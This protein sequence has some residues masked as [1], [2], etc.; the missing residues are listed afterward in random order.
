MLCVIIKLDKVS[1]NAA[2]NP[3]KVASSLVKV[4][5]MMRVIFHIIELQPLCAPY[6]T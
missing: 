4:A 6:K 2:L 3:I 1:V 5:D